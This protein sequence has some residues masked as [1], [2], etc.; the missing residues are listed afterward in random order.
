MAGTIYD[1]L[2]AAEQCEEEFNAAV[3]ARRLYRPQLHLRACPHAL[4]L[5][6]MVANF[7][8]LPPGAA[9]AAPNSPETLPRPGQP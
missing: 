7:P 9:T 1:V 3:L 4:P 6:R 8:H 2:V 5:W